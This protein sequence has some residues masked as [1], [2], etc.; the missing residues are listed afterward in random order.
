MISHM[1]TVRPRHQTHFFLL[2]F[3]LFDD[4]DALLCRLVGDD[5]ENVVTSDDGVLHLCVTPTVWILS[6]DAAYGAP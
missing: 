3:Y 4:D 2:F 6:P 5:V 1:T